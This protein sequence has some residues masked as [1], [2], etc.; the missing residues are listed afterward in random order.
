M[1]KV[2]QILDKEGEL[3]LQLLAK[4][5]LRHSIRVSCNVYPFTSKDLSEMNNQKE[6]ASR[7]S[8]FPICRNLAAFNSS[9]QNNSY[10]LFLAHC[11]R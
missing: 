7:S 1:C 3:M 4:L 11:K 2:W 8:G 5:E 6:T 10:L 9:M